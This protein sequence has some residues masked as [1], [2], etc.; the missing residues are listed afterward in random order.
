[1]VTEKPREAVIF[2][3]SS[4]RTA[5]AWHCPPPTGHIQKLFRSKFLASSRA[6]LLTFLPQ[7]RRAWRVF[8]SSVMFDG[9]NSPLG[10]LGANFSLIHFP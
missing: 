4:L 1:M 5:V 3:L 7:T 10:S 9:G 6:C 2:F 8:T